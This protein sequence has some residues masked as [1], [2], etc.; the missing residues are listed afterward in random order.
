MGTFGQDNGDGIELGA[1]A[2]VNGLNPAGFPGRQEGRAEF[3][4]IGVFAEYGS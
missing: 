2:F 4:L 1:L 3:T